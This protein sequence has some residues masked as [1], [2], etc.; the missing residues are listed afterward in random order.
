MNHNYVPCCL[1]DLHPKVTEQG[2]TSGQNK[3]AKVT[4]LTYQIANKFV[5]HQSIQG[6]GAVF[7][8]YISLRVDHHPMI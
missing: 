1:I 5:F 6:L 7:Q 4:F 2:S 8:Y 3:Y